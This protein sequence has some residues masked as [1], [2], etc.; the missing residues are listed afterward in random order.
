MIIK[1]C[2]EN[3]CQLSLIQVFEPSNSF[4]DF[5]PGNVHILDLMI[6]NREDEKDRQ[7]ILKWNCFY[8]IDPPDPE[9]MFGGVFF[10]GRMI[11]RSM[12]LWYIYRFKTTTLIEFL[13]TSK[14]PQNIAIHI[15]SV[16]EWF[17]FLSIYSTEG[18]KQ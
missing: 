18:S 17:E 13:W 2:I 5:L 8:W 6:S 11:E 10:I 15:L 1:F 14:C 3:G 9:S 16:S 12:Q 4:E 7:S